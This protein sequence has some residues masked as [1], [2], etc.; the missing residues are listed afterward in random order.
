MLCGLMPSRNGAEA[1][2]TFARPGTLGW[3]HYLRELGYDTAAFGKI[4]HGQDV[5]RWDFTHY[6]MQFD[7]GLV[8]SYVT[9]RSGD[10]PLCLFVGTHDPHVP[11]AKSTEYDPA[12]VKLPWN[13][14]DTPETRNFRANYYAEVTRAD[15]DMGALYDFIR[16]KLGTNTLFMFSSDHGAQ[17]PFGK[18]N[19]YD[20]SIRTPL[21]AAWPGVIKPGTRTDAMVSWVDFAP[22]LIELAGGTSPA[23]LDGKSFAGVLLGKA[24]MHRDEIYSTHSGDGKMNVYPIRALRTAQFKYIKNLHPE[25]EH[26]THIDR[27]RPLTYWPSWVAAAKTNAAAAEIVR[28]YHE[29]PAEELF[30][31]VRDPDE[32]LN[33]ATDPT[34]ASTLKEMRGKLEAW[35][36]S[37]GDSQKMFNTPYAKG[38]PELELPRRNPAGP[39]ATREAGLEAM[40]D[41]ASSKPARTKP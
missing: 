23:G 21:L 41:P 13:F 7:L 31:I 28:W 20:T 19:L 32:K 36:K 38:T 12:K 30:D 33:L 8:R 22:T 39:A 26:T 6:E 40:T 1:N 27:N 3:P 35:M 11:W 25:Y 18:W 29:R 16:Q 14:V 15:T 4:A 24:T 10:K 34:Y 17:W 37:Q 2:H 9:N 5:K